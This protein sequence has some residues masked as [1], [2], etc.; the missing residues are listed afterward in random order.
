MVT[1]L[2]SQTPGGF[3]NILFGIIEIGFGLVP[4][5]SSRHDQRTATRNED[6]SVGEKS[7]SMVL[8]VFP[9]Y[10]LHFRGKKSKGTGATLASPAPFHFR[11]FARSEESTECADD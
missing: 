1:P 3:P 4:R 2:E 9:R 5:S 11:G 7:R 6:L 8:A 10:G